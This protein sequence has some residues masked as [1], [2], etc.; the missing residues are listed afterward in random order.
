MYLSIFELWQ[1]IGEFQAV[2][3][4]MPPPP[5]SFLAF[6][7]QDNNIVAIGMQNSEIHIYYNKEEKV[8]ILS[9]SKFKFGLFREW[10]NDLPSLR[11]NIY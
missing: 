4:S 7:P 9:I 3:I 1:I 6:Y 10:Y 8:I 11:S 5:A 2:T